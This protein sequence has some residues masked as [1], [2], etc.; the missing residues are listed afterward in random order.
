M[1]YLEWGDA[2][3]NTGWMSENEA[4]EWAKEDHWVVKNVGWILEETKEYILLA[5]KYSD[6]SGEYGLLHKIPTTWIKVR[7]ELMKG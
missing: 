5:A 1:V 3:S 7:K 2:I 4:K 6:G